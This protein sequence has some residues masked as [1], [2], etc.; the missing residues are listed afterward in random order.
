MSHLFLFQIGI[1]TRPRHLETKRKQQTCSLVHD[2]VSLQHCLQS[3][4]LCPLY[5]VQETLTCFTQIMKMKQY[6]IM[7]L[8]CSP[9]PRGSMQYQNLHIYLMSLACCWTSTDLIC[10][11]N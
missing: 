2:D 10:E 11:D 5:E 8:C 6:S 7:M 3:V 9:D 1:R 4:T